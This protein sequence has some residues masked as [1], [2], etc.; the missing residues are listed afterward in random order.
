MLELGALAFA[1][2]WLL[3]GLLILPALWWLLRLTP[4]PPKRIDFPAIALLMGL[5]ARE[6]SAA[7][8]PWWVLLLRLLIAALIILA[9]AQPILSPQKLLSGNSAVVVVVDNGWASATGWQQRQAALESI[10]NEADRQGRAVAVLPTADRTGA[11]DGISFRPAEQWRAEVGALTPKPW[12]TNRQA[13]FEVLA[14]VETQ[15]ETIWLADGLAEPVDSDLALRLQR[16]GGLTVFA[17]EQGAIVL[18]EPGAASTGFVLKALRDRP[19]GQSEAVVQAI[20]Q[21]GRVVATQPLQFEGD[22]LSVEAEWKLPRDLANQVRQLRI[23]GRTGAGVTVLL[24]DRWQRKTVG[25]VNAGQ[26]TAG[27]PLLDP[28]HYIGSALS[29]IAVVEDGAL[30]EVLATRPSLVLTRQRLTPS[31]EVANA[32]NEWIDDGGILVRFA[33]PELAVSP[34]T[35]IPVRLRPTSR[36]MGGA[37]SWDRPQTLAPFGVNS[38]FT[39][40]EVPEDVLIRKQVLAEPAPD[41]R[42]KT[43]A[44]LEDGT[45]L[46]TAA[47]RGDGWVVLVH[48]TANADWSN[49]PL[50]GLFVEM[51]ARMVRLGQGQAAEFADDAALPPQLVLDG[52]G[53]L[54]EPTPEVRPLESTTEPRDLGPLHPPGYYGNEDGLRAWNLGSSVEN[55]D[56]Q[57]R[58]PIGVSERG[59]GKDASTDIAGWLWMAAFLLLL[60][61]FIASLALRGHLAIRQA[62]AAGVILAAL[63]MAVPGGSGFAQSANE[64]AFRHTLDTRLAFVR[65][66]NPDIDRVSRAGLAG[67]SRLLNDRT[68][69]EPGDP[70]GLDIANSELAFYP[71]IYWPV[72]PTQQLPSPDTRERI[73]AYLENGGTILF[74]TRDQFRLLSSGSGV[75][76]ERQH[77]RAILDGVRILPLEPVPQEHV[78]TKA[79]YL[80]Q[81]FP[82]RYAG[83]S[84]WVEANAAAA[85]DGV[86]SVI[87][88][89]HDWAAAWAV[90]RDGNYQ[91]AVV[92]GGERQREY[93]YRFGVNLVM[94]VLTGNYKGDQVHVPSILERLSQ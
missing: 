70:V 26:D 46:V 35:W 47:N 45:P 16:L 77:L 27:H 18:Q 49:L 1:Q 61:D 93:A 29:G 75:T 25:L 88:G 20:A 17:P 19:T 82:G 71:L 63:G 5:T 22:E 48:V 39:G 36:T 79:F 91:F 42:E 94:H 32:L 11:W 69:I 62:T 80:I 14:G 74:D 8:T 3:A 21:D 54:R 40:L 55:L 73:A 43:W 67:L 58:W 84:V 30:G 15:L 87:I 89:P 65:T 37:L 56:P 9:L 81:E 13:V 38:P 12:K 4:P 31:S 86:S 60:A 78:L 6:E 59:Y 52:F 33:G 51:L 44:S 23:D 92:P 76:P 28:A 66:G 57:S 34:D 10:L 64:E 53:Q 85:R 68:S 41:L 50:S 90:D 24:D 7:R 83:G 72:T 2:P